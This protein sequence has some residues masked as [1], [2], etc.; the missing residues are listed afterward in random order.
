MEL[1]P[2]VTLFFEELNLLVSSFVISPE[3]A[4]I[5]LEEDIIRTVWST[6][7]ELA[8]IFLSRFGSKV[9]QSSHPIINWLPRSI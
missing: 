6:S 4:N 3:S 9:Q 5:C 1:Y 2:T 8:A 7:L